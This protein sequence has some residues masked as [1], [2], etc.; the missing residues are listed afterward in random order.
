MN[1]ERN[2]SHDFFE[3][4]FES[5]VGEEMIDISPEKTHENPV[6]FVPGWNAKLFEYKN[7]FKSIVTTGKRRVISLVP[8][9]NEDE[10]AQE[11]I[12]LIKSKDF[13]EVDVI[14]HSVGAI[15]TE[16]AGIIEPGLLKKIILINPPVDEN[17]PRDLI[18]K[19]KAM[20]SLE[21][22]KNMANV[23]GR[24]IYEMANV[25]TSFDMHA[26][27][28]HLRNLGTKVFSIHGLSDTLFPPPEDAKNIN[29]MNLSFENT[30]FYV[31]G[32]HLR[33]DTFIL[34][35]L[36]LLNRKT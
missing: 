21:D 35:A 22:A 12:D 2:F 20:L 28:Q 13:S 15:C 14:A 34:P 11:L 36:N 23:G 33:I 31:E 18:R 24:K 10:K 29:D 30:E 7:S 32:K 9:G 8:N 25:I 1:P 4:Q 5:Q 3:E 17:D 26:M 16:I 27:K 19:Y 6:L